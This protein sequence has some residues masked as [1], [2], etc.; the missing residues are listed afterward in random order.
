[1]KTSISLNLI[2]GII[3]CL[4]GLFCFLYG[5]EYEFGSLSHIGPGFF[6]KI[7]SIVIM[8]VGLLVSISR[9]NQKISIE[10]RSL[11]VCSGSI[12]IFALC[13][14]FLGLLPAIFFTIFSSLYAQREK[15]SLVKKIKITSGITVFILVLF[16]IFFQMS[17]EL[18]YL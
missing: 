16:K 12:V 14:K 3:I 10:Y 5:Y 15:I 13:I 1:M 6:P 2:S 11:F 7:I 18:L 8:V 17:T 9:S 4:F